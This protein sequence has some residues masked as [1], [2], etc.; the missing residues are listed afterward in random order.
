MRSLIFFTPHFPFIPQ[1]FIPLILCLLN[2]NKPCVILPYVY[3]NSPTNPTLRSLPALF[4]VVP[5]FVKNARNKE[6][7]STKNNGME[8]VKW[9][10]HA[11]LSF[12]CLSSLHF[13]FHY[14][15]AKLMEIKENS[16]V[17]LF[18]YNSLYFILIWVFCL[19]YDL[20]VVHQEPRTSHG[21]GMK[22]IMKEEMEWIHAL[23]LL[24]FVIHSFFFIFNS[25]FTPI[26]LW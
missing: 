3:F 23:L 20:E 10:K 24:S 6:Q 17:P 19:L 18:P 9:R 12:H 2:R 11:S 21:K 26:S 8:I 1:H 7:Q 15:R 4:F 14:K 22:W 25:F 5:L 13:P 16:C